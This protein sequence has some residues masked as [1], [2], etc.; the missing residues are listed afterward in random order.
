MAH[1]FTIYVP[2]VGYAEASEGTAG[3]RNARLHLGRII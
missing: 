1:R 3:E 2:F